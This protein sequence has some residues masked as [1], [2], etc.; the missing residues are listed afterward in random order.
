MPN[1]ITFIIILFMSTSLIYGKPKRN[2]KSYEKCN[3]AEIFQSFTMKKNDNVIAAIETEIYGERNFNYSKVLSYTENGINFDYYFYKIEN[4][5]LC[6]GI[7]AYNGLQDDAVIYINTQKECGSKCK[8]YLSNSDKEEIFY[9]WEPLKEIIPNNKKEKLIIK[10]DKQDFIIMIWSEIK[11]L[12]LYA[13]N[14]PTIKDIQGLEKFQNLE[15][16]SLIG[17]DY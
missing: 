6:L 16:L 4:D 3:M 10:T 14:F 8:V 2:Y 15:S 7:K 11:E 17:F 13:E 9:I 12:E 1:K 5:N